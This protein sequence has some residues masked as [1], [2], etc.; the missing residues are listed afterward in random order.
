MGLTFPEFCVDFGVAYVWI[1]P[2]SPKGLLQ[3]GG[4]PK[5]GGSVGSA[6][7]FAPKIVCLGGGVTSQVSLLRRGSMALGKR[8]NRAKT[9]CM[10]Q[11]IALPGSNNIGKCV[12]NVCGGWRGFLTPS[13]RAL[14]KEKKGFSSL[15]IHWKIYRKKSRKN[16]QFFG[17]K[18]GRFC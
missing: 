6:P 11:W 14:V 9:S 10:A 7:K 15:H 1:L 12:L 13:T 4:L 2:W 17:R 16:G 8:S 5:F 18:S 3:L